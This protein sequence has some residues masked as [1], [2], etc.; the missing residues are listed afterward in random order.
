MSQGEFKID[1]GWQAIVAILSGQLPGTDVA[2]ISDKDFNE[3]G[4]IIMT[5][6]SVRVFF[7]GEVAESTSDSQRLS[8]LTNGRY[9]VLCADQD[10]HSV[11]AQAYASVQL[12]NKV[13]EL[14]AGARLLLTDGDTSEPLI[15]MGTTPIPVEGIGVAYGVE[16]I[17]PGLAQFPGTNS[18]AGQ[19]I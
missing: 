19:V 1:Q 9:G 2:A 7:N 6:P 12:V 5:P 8:Y 4:E 18:V 10:Y 14:L 13:K 16:F 17:V 15:Y 3:D 11:I